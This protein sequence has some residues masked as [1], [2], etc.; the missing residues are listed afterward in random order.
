MNALRRLRPRARRGCSAGCRR[1]GARR[2]RSA[3]PGSA[4]TS[5]ACASSQERRDRGYRQRDVVL[6]VR[7]LAPLRFGDV[8]AQR[9]QRRALRVGL[10]RSSRPRR[11]R[12]STRVGRALASSAS[13]RLAFAGAVVDLHQHVPRVP[14]QRV[15]R[16][17]M[18][19]ARQGERERA[20][21]LEADEPVGQSAA[22][23]SVSRRTAASTSGTAASAVARAR[24][25]GK[26]FSTAAVTM[27]S[28][29]SAPMNSCLR[30]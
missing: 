8:L 12:R 9:P 1:P 6:D 16:F 20:H 3:T 21:E 7:T 4:S 24:G 26:S 10:R 23:S 17:R 11:C 30:S 18:V 25:A 5:A 28:V 13:R 14:G 2:S 19:L 15:G 27:P 22:L 29:P